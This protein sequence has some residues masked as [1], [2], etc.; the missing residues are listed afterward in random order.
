MQAHGDAHKVAR[1]LP[2]RQIVVDAG[3][4]LFKVQRGRPA[5]ADNLDTVHPVLQSL[6]KHVLT[7]HH[8]QATA[9]RS[10]KRT[11]AGGIHVLE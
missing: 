6:A 8:A 4:G 11:E 1:R 3:P 5:D 10:C 9:P 7:A 2:Y